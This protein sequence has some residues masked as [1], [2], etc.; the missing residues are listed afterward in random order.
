MVPFR[1]AKLRLLRWLQGAR[2]GATSR[3]ATLLLPPVALLQLIGRAAALELGIDISDYPTYSSD[4][5]DF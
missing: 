3:C 5:N 2:C 4:H 1:A